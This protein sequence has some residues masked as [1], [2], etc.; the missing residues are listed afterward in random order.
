MNAE[1]ILQSKLNKVK[2]F[3]DNES[4]VFTFSK[5]NAFA[6][7][8]DQLFKNQ[9]Y[10][11]YIDHNGYEINER[12][13]NPFIK[14]EKITQI[15]NKNFL[16]NSS[17]ISINDIGQNIVYEP[18]EN[19][20][21]INS[22]KF[23]IKE[24]I[25]KI[26]SANGKI[27]YND[28]NKIK[29]IDF[30]NLNNLTIHF[31]DKDEPFK[32]FK[33][34]KST[35]P[36][37]VITFNSGN[38]RDL[39]F[40]D[41]DY[42]HNGTIN[43]ENKKH[44]ILC[45]DV[46]ML[47]N[48]TINKGKSLINYIVETSESES[49]F[50]FDRASEEIYSDD[51]Y[52]GDTIKFYNNDIGFKVASIKKKCTSM[53]FYY[54]ITNSYNNIYF[55]IDGNYYN[56]YSYNNDS[57][58]RMQEYIG[59]LTNEEH[60]FTWVLY[61]EYYS[62]SSIDTISFNNE[63]LTDS[64]L[65]TN[66][67]DNDIFSSKYINNE[68]KE[69]IINNIIKV[70]DL[71][72]YKISKSN[73]DKKIYLYIDYG[74]SNNYDNSFYC[75]CIAG[76]I[77]Y[78]LYPGINLIET[79]ATEIYIDIFQNRKV[80]FSVLTDNHI[81]NKN[82]LI[83]YN[84]DQAG[85]V[86]YSDEYKNGD[87]SSTPF[88]NDAT[89]FKVVS[90][91][92]TCS[93]MS[94][95][96]KT[97]YNADDNHICL[98][99]D[100]NYY[101]KYSNNSTW[102]LITVDNLSN[103]EHEFTW[104]LYNTDDRDYSCIDT[105]SFNDV[106]E[107]DSSLF[108]NSIESFILK[109]KNIIVLQSDSK[110]IDFCICN[111]YFF[112]DDEYILH[113]DNY[114]VFVSNVKKILNKQIIY[115]WED[116]DG[117][118]GIINV[119]FLLDKNNRLKIIVDDSDLFGDTY[120]DG[121]FYEGIFEALEEEFKNKEI[122]DIACNNFT[123]DNSIET[124]YILT[125]SGEVYELTIT[126][127][128]NTT[129]ALK[130][131]NIRFVD[132]KK[133]EYGIILLGEDGKLYVKGKF[134]NGEFGLYNTSSI[135]IDGKEYS[136]AFVSDKL[137]RI[138]RDEFLEDGEYKLRNIYTLK[139]YNTDAYDSGVYVVKEDGKLY[140]TG[141]NNGACG[142]VFGYPLEAQNIDVWTPVENNTN[143]IGRISTPRPDYWS[144]YFDY[145]MKS[146]KNGSGNSVENIFFKIDDVWI[147]WNAYISKYMNVTLRDADNKILKKYKEF[148]KTDNSTLRKVINFDSFIEYL[149]LNK[150]S[151]TNEFKVDR[152]LIPQVDYIDKDLN[153]YT[154]N[155]GDN[156]SCIKYSQ[157]D[158]DLLNADLIE[159]L[160]H[161]I[162]LKNEYEDVIEKS[163]DPEE[164]FEYQNRL[165]VIEL[166]IEEL[167][168][169]IAN[170]QDK[171]GTMNPNNYFDF[172]DNR[173]FNPMT[174]VGTEEKT[175][176]Y[177]K[178]N[179]SEPNENGEIKIE[180]EEIDGALHVVKSTVSKTVESNITKLKIDLIN[181]DRLNNSSISDA[182]V[183][184]DDIKMTIM[185]DP[186]D[187]RNF[188]V[189]DLLVWLNGKFITKDY[190][191]GNDNKAFCNYNG[192]AGVETR[193]ICEFP[194]YGEPTQNS[195][196]IPTITGENATVIEPTVPTELRWDL[197][198]KV[199]SWEDVKINGPYKIHDLN[200]VNSELRR[201]EFFYFGD[202]YCSVFTQF[203]IKN[204]IYPKNTFILFFNGAVVPEDEYDVSIKGNNTYI[205]LKKFTAYV[206]SLLQDEVDIMKPGYEGR[207]RH[208]LSQFDN[209]SQFSI[210]FL[211]STDKFKKVKMYY[212]Y[213]TI[214]DVP[215]PGQVIFNDIKY[216]DLIL[217]DGRY[218]PYLWESRH[219]IRIPETVDTIRTSENN[220]IR[221]S[222]ICRARPY[223]TYKKESELTDTEC[224]MYAKQN[225]L[226]NDEELSTLDIAYIR[227]RVKP[228]IEA[229]IKEI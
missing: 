125:K 11:T 215:K 98:Y 111:D 69:N 153:V 148:K 210:A 50:K 63:D 126:P 64:S 71:G 81:F 91:K 146:D 21:E 62:E 53:V 68:I 105:I 194:G 47:R 25:S 163:Q 41:D 185:E 208:I 37:D 101:N 181:Y 224:R 228:H 213:Q 149:K 150:E 35:I 167:N 120:Y 99:I 180:T 118:Y 1:N 172:N 89:G 43:L 140:Y 179:F 75:R 214:R 54:E 183:L 104:V 160:N 48:A 225:G 77:K 137:V 83:K 116:Y 67:Y 175:I 189:D 32:P 93:K 22:K 173:I 117:H 20:I 23:K 174:V 44:I 164:I 219:C 201:V 30:L 45:K 18:K 73:N 123:Y 103:K 4:F 2:S 130:Y 27:F 61:N 52:Y 158:I 159:S 110:I 206:T 114:S 229:K 190:I 166:N 205:T 49:N 100:G 31:E 143:D 211:S 207:V 187:E 132:M 128:E 108:S 76:D 202:V 176:N 196:N 191:I 145:I 199:F 85:I 221:H 102:E 3:I 192:L 42:H 198:P 40:I 15:L 170:N 122:K 134:V 82:E 8:K 86:L 154:I 188:E 87:N 10:K 51:Y 156:I 38:Y 6:I 142:E 109:N 193:R 209:M 165:A 151:I 9:V 84:K 112:I 133:T 29:S 90:I 223:S 212:D 124:I 95:Y 178:S 168:K 34:Y 59:S 36:F 72:F 204:K 58:G 13:N 226:I 152:T 200:N 80:Y 96:Y 46:E 70:D 56:K 74:N 19:E 106:V 147:D 139:L 66:N 157:K 135:T 162:Q 182:E 127:P 55:Y 5:T 88:Y 144:Y 26:D 121:N 97:K 171:L 65:V 7:N 113:N 119:L 138:S 129:V 57:Y 24:N 217:F 195:N 92:K 177:S 79:E 197:S 169:E 94:F 131:D 227:E 28:D 220:F 39:I 186:N 155:A 136:K 17:R 33:L 78:N 161:N 12:K 216:N 16:F 60:E 14:N 222:T 141:K 107:I 203:L 115:Y 184:R 218:I